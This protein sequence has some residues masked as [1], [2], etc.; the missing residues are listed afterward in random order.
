MIL[1]PLRWN[2]DICKDCLLVFS[3][4]FCWAGMKL[5]I[6]HGISCMFLYKRAPGLLSHIDHCLFYFHRL[7]QL[8]ESS[9]VHY[10]YISSTT[11]SFLLI[12]PFQLAP[13]FFAWMMFYWWKSS[14]LLGVFSLILS[15]MLFSLLCWYTAIENLCIDFNYLFSWYFFHVYPWIL[16]QYFVILV[17]FPVQ[18]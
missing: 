7:A 15:S 2:I 14:N 9:Q 4:L 10:G 3:I 18:T 16:I 6:F 5:N 11:Y 1:L 13:S 12:S 17:Y 8:L